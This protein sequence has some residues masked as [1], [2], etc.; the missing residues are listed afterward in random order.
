M[1]QKGMSATEAED[2]LKVVYEVSVFSGLEMLTEKLGL[3]CIR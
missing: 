3:V 2:E 1:V